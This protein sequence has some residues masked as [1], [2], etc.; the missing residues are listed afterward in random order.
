MRFSL[1]GQQFSEDTGRGERLN[2]LGQCLRPHAALIEESEPL[3]AAAEHRF[4]D[5]CVGGADLDRLHVFELRSANLI[6]VIGDLGPGDNGGCYI[7]RAN[8]VLDL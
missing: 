5:S 3:N 4:V 7:K 2:E 8:S 6:E 1:L